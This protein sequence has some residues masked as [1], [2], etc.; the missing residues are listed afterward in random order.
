MKM[1]LLHVR[2]SLQ[3]LLI[4]QLFDKFSRVKTL[5]T[6]IHT[7]CIIGG[8]QLITHTHK[9]TQVICMFSV[10]TRPLR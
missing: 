5:V 9:E 1:N 10:L 4:R 2:F 8:T 7:S 6:Y 3:S